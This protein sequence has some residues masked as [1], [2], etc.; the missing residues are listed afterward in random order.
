MDTA[1]APHSTG[2]APFHSNFGPLAK[3]ISLVVVGDGAEHS[4]ELVIIGGKFTT[5]SDGKAPLVYLTSRA[6]RDPGVLLDPHLD[7]AEAV[8]P[9]IAPHLENDHVVVIQEGGR[10]RRAVP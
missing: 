7:L 1:K 8:R 3:S 10:A 9:D 4:R 6:P 5:R 2:F